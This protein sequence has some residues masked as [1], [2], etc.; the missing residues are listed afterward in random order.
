MAHVSNVMLKIK[1]QVNSKSNFQSAKIL[2]NFD[3]SPKLFLTSYFF[4]LDFPW[5][6]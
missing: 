3:N 5:L 4:L 6:S 1:Q 2:Y